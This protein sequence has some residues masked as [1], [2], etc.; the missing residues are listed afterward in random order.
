MRRT[1]S[2][3]ALALVAV[4]SLRGDDPSLCRFDKVYIKPSTSYYVIAAVTMT[5]PPFVRRNSVFSSTYSARVFPYFVF[6]EKGRIW[7]MVSE[8]QLRQVAK[9]ESVDFTGRAIS[10][11]GDTRKVTGRATPTGPTSGDIR[12]RV[13]VSKRIS[14]TCNTVYEL[15][16]AAPPHVA[17][18]PR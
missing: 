7:I 5:M 2:I 17:V 16:G 14:L 12:V 9:G 13:Y 1:F 8:D 6:S 4:A 3:L 10:E 15:E 11:D 18:T